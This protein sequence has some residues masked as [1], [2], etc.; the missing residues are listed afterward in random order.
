MAETAV[1]RNFN[2]ERKGGRLKIAWK[3]KM[4]ATRARG[5]NIEET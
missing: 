4:K 5:L 1:K 2:R 3:T